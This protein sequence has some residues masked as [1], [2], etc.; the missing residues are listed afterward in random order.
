[1]SGLHTGLRRV[2]SC[3]GGVGSVGDQRENE[4]FT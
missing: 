4:A 2:E 3:A 1:V